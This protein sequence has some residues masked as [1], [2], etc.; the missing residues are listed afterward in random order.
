L[1]DWMQPSVIAEP[2][3]P[4]RPLLRHSIVADRARYAG[5]S[6]AAVI[7]ESVAQA[8]DAAELVEVEYNEH[9]AVTTAEAALAD[10][11]PIVH[12][13]WDNNM[14][15][16][17]HA[18]AGDVD[19][20]FTAAPHHVNLRLVLPRIASVYIEPKAVLAT[21]DAFDERM[22]VWASTQT[23]HG[24]RTQISAVLDIP[25]NRIRVIAPDVGGAFG[26]KGRHVPDYLFAAA[27]SKKL[28][29]PVKWVE[30][31]SEYFHI[32]NQARDQVQYIDAAVQGDGTITGIRVRVY[33]NLGAYNASGH[34]G[35]TLIMSG[36]AYNVPN[37][38]TDIYGVMTH[39]TPTGPYRGAGRP[40]AAYMVERL[41]EEIAR[42]TGIDS[43]ELRRRNFIQSDM[44]PYR[45]ATGVTY[46]SGNYERA[47]D[48]ALEHLDIATERRRVDELRAAGKL[49][50]IGV[51]VFVEPSGGGWDSADVRVSPSG[52]VTVSVGVSP[53]G[54]GTDV[55]IRQ[56]VAEQLGLPIEQIELRASDTDTTPQGIGTFGS[57]SLAVGGGAAIVAAT[58]VANKV[59]SLAGAMLETATDDIELK[60]S[61][62]RVIGAPDRWLPFSR[63]AAAAHG[64]GNIPGGL[65]PGLDETAFFTSEG[66]QFPFGVH[67]AVVV[68][69][70]DTGRLTVDRFIGV[71]DC[72]TIINPRMVEGQV[73]G[74]LAQGFGQALWEEVVFN[75]DGQLITGSLMDYAIPHADQLPMFELD[76]TETPSQLTPHGAKGVGEAGTTGAP[77]AL[78]NAALDALRPLGVTHIDMPL[79]SEKIWRAIHGATRTTFR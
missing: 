46:D 28:G 43:L 56:L 22:T 67:I 78:V 37:L 21:W 68:I 75:E 20:A 5:D 39:T 50:G 53:H 11:A 33:V 70:P 6:V 23:P 12:D 74:G 8:T 55:A 63:V 18:G 41:I 79:P 40:E 26:T 38:V 58:Q 2:L 7:A 13:G 24:M 76:H 9:P 17:L 61:Q 54:Q 57:R 47:L 31:R 62:A 45:A 59:R 34:G 44:F 36:G 51:A 71:D 65:E 27:A 35:R 4:N 73:I 1:G 48:L 77:P 29:R 60:E 14:A 10:D 19:A 30:D 72:G 66:N 16:H 25:E 52:S 64:M 42:V 3:L 15:Y 32:A 49:A 69:D